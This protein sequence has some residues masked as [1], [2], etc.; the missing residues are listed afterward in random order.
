MVLSEVELLEMT[1]KFK[2]IDKEPNSTEAIP[3]MVP[4]LNNLVYKQHF[5]QFL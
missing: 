1:D 3:G 2:K 4:E 5:H